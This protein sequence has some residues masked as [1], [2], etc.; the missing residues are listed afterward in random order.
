MADPDFMEKYRQL[1]EKD[2]VERFRGGN[3][4]P[5]EQRKMDEKLNALFV[6]NIVKTIFDYDARQDLIKD[7]KG[8]SLEEKHAFLLKEFG[9]DARLQPDP[10][11]GELKESL[12]M[13][14]ESKRDLKVPVCRKCKKPHNPFDPCFG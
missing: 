5:V 7:F 12:Q 2:G 1:K 6:K 10:K 9:M 14:D 11:P 3:L 8:L 4:D 13:Y